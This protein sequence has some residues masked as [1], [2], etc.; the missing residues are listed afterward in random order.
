ML[1]WTD[2]DGGTLRRQHTGYRPEFL[3]NDRRKLRKKPAAAGAIQKIQSRF[4]N[5]EYGLSQ[6]SPS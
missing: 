2:F 5:A 1:W 6:V 4:H 3:V